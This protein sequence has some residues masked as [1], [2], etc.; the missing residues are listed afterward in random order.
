M[1]KLIVIL[2]LSMLSACGTFGLPTPDSYEEKLAAGY[3]TATNL[4][5]TTSVLLSASKIS[6]E[7]ALN[8]RKTATTASE[9]LD[10]AESLK[11]ASPEVAQS[12][13]DVSIASLEALKKYLESR[14]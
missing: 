5:L 7:D 13:L 3:T 6:S 1:K 10:I 8:I 12:R 2:C 4:V 9:G 11:A 14:K